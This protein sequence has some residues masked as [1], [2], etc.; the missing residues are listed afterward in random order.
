MSRK[1]KAQAKASG[2]ELVKN[3]VKVSLQGLGIDLENA[4]GIPESLLDIWFP[5]KNFPQGFWKKQTDL[6]RK[7]I[8]VTDF[9]WLKLAEDLFLVRC[10]TKKDQGYMISFQRR[11]A[12]E[13][14]HVLTEG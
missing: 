11:L 13:M 7:D 8:V 10:E 9:K 2:V 12:L 5:C 3:A 1:R 6:M 4:E 14:D